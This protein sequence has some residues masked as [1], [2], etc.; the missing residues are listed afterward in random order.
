MLQRVKAK[1]GMRRVTAIVRAWQRKRLYASKS[2]VK[3]VV[4]YVT[5]RNHVAAACDSVRA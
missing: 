3:Q 5:L 4:M 2:V 1:E